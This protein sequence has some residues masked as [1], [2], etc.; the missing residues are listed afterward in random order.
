MSGMN[1]EFTIQGM[2]KGM[3]PLQIGAQGLAETV[4]EM[5]L[6]T[7]PDATTT[8]KKRCGCCTK[9][10]LLSD[11]GC[12]KCDSRFCSTHRLP[13][14]HACPYDFKKEGQALLAKQNPRV[15]GDKMERC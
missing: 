4:P 6:T 3:T 8:N 12:S 1:H 9:K 11:V 2:L 5:R 13:E 10:L 7:A 15:I 14:L